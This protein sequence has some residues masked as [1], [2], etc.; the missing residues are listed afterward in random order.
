M[1]DD[2]D[3]RICHAFGAWLRE[4]RRRKKLSQVDLAARAGISAT[5]LSEIEQGERNPTIA[6]VVRLARA[7]DVKATQLVSR[8]DD[9]K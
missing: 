1:A 7:L 8:L 6:V 4:L 3:A 2:G 5:Y 9:V